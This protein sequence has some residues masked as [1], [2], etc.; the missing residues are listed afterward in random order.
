VASGEINKARRQKYES[1]REQ[2]NRVN[3]GLPVRDAIDSPEAG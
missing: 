3:Q 2:K 1:R